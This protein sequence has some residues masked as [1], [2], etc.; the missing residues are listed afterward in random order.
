MEPIIVVMIQV[1]DFEIINTLKNKSLNPE[2][3]LVQKTY[4]TFLFFLDY[5]IELN[6]K[7]KIL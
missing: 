7:Q 1:L 6:I 5:S 3:Y 2:D 4:A